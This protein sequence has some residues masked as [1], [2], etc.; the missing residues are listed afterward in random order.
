MT[1]N[2]PIQ[3]R[4]WKAQ[5]TVEG[6]VAY[7]RVDDRDAPPWRERSQPTQ[8]IVPTGAKATG[9]V[10]AKRKRPVATKAPNVARRQKN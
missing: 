4:Q 5:S 1:P 3:L 2:A 6:K 8:K 7:S 9:A 10:R